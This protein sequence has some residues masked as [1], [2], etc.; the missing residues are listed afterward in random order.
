M[1]LSSERKY[2]HEVYDLIEAKAGEKITKEDKVKICII[3]KNCL[4]EK[5][6]KQKTEIINLEKRLKYL[7]D[8]KNKEPKK[9]IKPTPVKSEGYWG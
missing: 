7:Y 3:F 4:K 5:T 8:K 6:A 1:A 2:R 9:I